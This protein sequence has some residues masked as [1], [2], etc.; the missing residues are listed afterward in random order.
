MKETSEMGAVGTDLLLLPPGKW[1]FGG[2]VIGCTSG[3]QE[4]AA[5]RA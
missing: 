5:V 2:L 4:S 1:G 3:G